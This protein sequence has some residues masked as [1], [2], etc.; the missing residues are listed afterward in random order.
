MVQGERIIYFKQGNIRWILEEANT[1]NS[2]I[3]LG[4]KLGVDFRFHLI[5]EKYWMLRSVLERI[6]PG[7][8]VSFSRLIE[9]YISECNCYFLDKKEGD[10]RMITQP[11]LRALQIVTRKK[12]TED[13]VLLSPEG[14][15]KLLARSS[16][17][18]RKIVLIWLTRKLKEYRLFDFK[19]FQLNLFKCMTPSE[20]IFYA[21]CY[22][23]FPS[24]K[25]QLNISRMHVDFAIGNV[26][27]EIDGE[28][29]LTK[30]Q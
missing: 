11:E 16:N 30:E 6:Y 20:R 18:N 27:F 1:P 21:Y 23:F 26:V 4:V 13:M 29:H 9:E 22:E 17:R 2:L 15:I 14:V 3:D 5:D 28:Y 25:S 10:Y 7:I 19:N 24:M 12:S 8:R